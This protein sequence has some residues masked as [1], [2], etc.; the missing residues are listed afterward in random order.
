ARDGRLPHLPP[1]PTRRSSDLAGSDER[2]T[3]VENL[4]AKA[5]YDRFLSD[6]LTA[7]AAVSALRDRFQGL[8]LRTNFD[9]GLAY[10]IVRDSDLRSEEHTSELQSRENLVCRLL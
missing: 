2:E 10:Y 8:A 5:R 1:L 4:Q 3:N 7:F 6:R 9:P